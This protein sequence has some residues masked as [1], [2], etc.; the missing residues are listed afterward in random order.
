MPDFTGDAG[1]LSNRYL[2]ERARALDDI[3]IIQKAK[4]LY[5]DEQGDILI[6]EMSI[7]LVESVD[8]LDDGTGAWVLAWVYVPIVGED[9]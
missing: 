9:E 5:E 8:R 3:A 4:D 1:Q 6:Q 7:D 2:Q